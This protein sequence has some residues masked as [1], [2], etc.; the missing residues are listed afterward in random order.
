[1]AHNLHFIR[2][3]ADTGE[4]ACGVA[5]DYLSEWGTE[6]NWRTMCGAISQ[7]NEVFDN[8]DAYGGGRF[9]PSEIGI[10]SIAQINETVDKWMEGTFYGNTAKELLESGKPIHEFNRHELWSLK[11]YVKFLYQLKGFQGDE[12]DKKFNA[13]V[14]E[15]YPYE[16]DECGLTDT[17][18]YYEGKTWIVFCDM[19]S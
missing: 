1:M 6:N 7:D 11:E 14:D 3:I 2:V 9:K 15:Y 16:Y 4:D 8:N 19:H 17:Q 12:K 13:L 10:T 5:E 18:N